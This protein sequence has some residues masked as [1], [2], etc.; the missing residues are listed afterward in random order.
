MKKLKQDTSEDVLRDE[1][2]LNQN[3]NPASDLLKLYFIIPDMGSNLVLSFDYLHN[4]G[5]FIVLERIILN[6][7]L[8]LGEHS[9]SESA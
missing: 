4:D 6:S 5:N 2:K 7:V 8:Q 9:Y 3:T 1:E